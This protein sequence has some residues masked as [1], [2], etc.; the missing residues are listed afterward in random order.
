LS[1]ADGASTPATILGS[2]FGARMKIYTKHALPRILDVSMDNVRLHRL[3]SRLISQAK[4]R[5]LEIGIGSGLNLPH[6]SNAVEQICGIDCSPFSLGICFRRAK[7][8]DKPVLL[9]QGFAEALPFPD[10]TF[11]TIVTTWTLC[12]IDGIGEALLELRRTLKPAGHLLFLEHG[13]SAENRVE[14]W[15][16]RLTCIT[17]RFGG[18]CRINRPISRLILDAGFTISA[19]RNCYSGSLK[20]FVYMYEGVA[21]PAGAIR[22]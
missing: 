10:H 9:V 13:R 5:I 17:K 3:R 20:P 8:L 18:G 7:R 11:D 14:W 15:Q 19:L 16:D 4:G 1:R 12:S 21:T 22:N 2:I 6:Y